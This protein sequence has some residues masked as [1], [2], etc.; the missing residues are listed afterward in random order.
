MLMLIGEIQQEQRQLGTVMRDNQ[1]QVNM[2]KEKHIRD[3]PI[4]MIECVTVREAM[5]KHF[6]RNYKRSSLKVIL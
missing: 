5:I 1:A 3:C 6:T 2:V 4:L